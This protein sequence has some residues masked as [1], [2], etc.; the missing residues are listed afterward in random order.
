VLPTVKQLILLLKQQK[1]ELALQLMLPMLLVLSGHN[2]TTRTQTSAPRRPHSSATTR[3]GRRKNS[4]LRQW[5][6]P[7]GLKIQV[8]QEHT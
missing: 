3:L 1:I 5:Q 4:L 6:L 2:T 7:V 8:M